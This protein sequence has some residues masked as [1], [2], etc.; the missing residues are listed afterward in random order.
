MVAVDVRAVKQQT[1]KQVWLASSERVYAERVQELGAR[2]RMIWE[3]ILFW[4]I[5]EG[6]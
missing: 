3:L 5:H 6:D 2:A 1:A 4:C